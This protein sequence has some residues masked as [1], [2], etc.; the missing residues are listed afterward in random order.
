MWVATVY[1]SGFEEKGMKHNAS[2]LRIHMANPA[3]KFQVPFS[4]PPCSSS[5]PSSS[6][7][8][9]RR[10]PGA[11]VKRASSNKDM[12]SSS[13]RDLLFDLGLKLESRR[14]RFALMFAVVSDS[15]IEVTFAGI[16][17]LPSVPHGASAGRRS[18]RA[19]TEGQCERECVLE[20]GGRTRGVGTKGSG[21]Q[22]NGSFWL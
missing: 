9:C 6:D 3:L 15:A 11:V 7:Q 1:R 5:S 17:G 13:A 21:A 20:P 4:S 16:S 22:T 2:R 10:S 18:G 14:F 8:C 19:A 12:M